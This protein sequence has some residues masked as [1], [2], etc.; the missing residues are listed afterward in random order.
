[1]GRYSIQST[2]TPSSNIIIDGIYRFSIISS[3]II[4]VEKDKTSTFED[5]PTQIVFHRNINT[6]DFTYKIIKDKVLIVTK[7]TDFLYDKK[8]DKAYVIKDKYMIDSSK[9]IGNLKGTLRTLDFTAG[10]VHLQDGI[11]SKQGVTQID[12]SASYVINE[13]GNVKERQIKEKDI[14]V[15]NFG[16]D[17]FGG[18]KEFYSLT[19]YTPL[20]PKYVLCKCL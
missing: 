20:L 9:R 19:G 12:D 8:K 13:E 17:Y 6:P 5:L 18:I 4:R 15:L 14:Y 3:R 7:D 2:K 10:L 11:F 1:M 16:Q